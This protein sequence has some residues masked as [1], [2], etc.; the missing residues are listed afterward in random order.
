[1]G[2]FGRGLIGKRPVGGCSRGERGFVRRGSNEETGLK[3]VSY[4]V[5]VFEEAGGVGR[6]ITEAKDLIAVDARRGGGIIKKTVTP[7]SH[8]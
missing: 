7:L 1:M 5:A 6:K 8:L 4:E 2:V 3:Q